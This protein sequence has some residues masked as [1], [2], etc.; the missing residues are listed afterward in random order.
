MK[1]KIYKK[2]IEKL[3]QAQELERL[4]KTA[5]N[6]ERLSERSYYGVKYLV[7]KKIYEGA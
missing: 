6:D 1:F 4:L 3:T 5:E 2:A 7:L